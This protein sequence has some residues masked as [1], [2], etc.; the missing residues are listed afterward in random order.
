MNI[1]CPNYSPLEM[2][3]NLRIAS[4]SRKWRFDCLLLPAM[5]NVKLATGLHSMWRRSGA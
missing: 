2:P 1:S 3:F 5:R 4:G